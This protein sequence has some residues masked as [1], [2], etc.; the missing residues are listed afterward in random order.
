MSPNPIILYLHVPKTGGTT[1][2]K[3]H[4]YNNYRTDDRYTAEAYRGKPRLHD[5]IYYFPDGFYNSEPDLSVP[6]IV[7]RALGRK[8]LRAVT[9]HFCF[10]IHRHVTGPSTYITLLRNPVDRIVSLYYHIRRWANPDPG[11][12]DEIISQGVSLDEFV[13]RFPLR[14]LYND[15]T[16]RI[17]GREP[18][19]GRRA[20]LALNKAKVNLRQHF[21]VVGVTERFNETLILLRRSFGWTNDLRYY[22]KHV[23]RDRPSLDALPPSSVAAIM[24]RNESDLE[25]HRFAMELLDEAIASQDASF[26]DDL[27]RF[28]SLNAEYVRTLATGGKSAT[29]LRLNTV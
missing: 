28:E 5:G 27:K 13:T 11:L 22:P 26:G 20:R 14:E 21:S 6:E 1:L 10:G 15:Q 2:R 23:T 29:T 25:L 3:V 16:R 8:G 19:E 17:S 4:I 18:E 9:G 12:H 7:R 24:E